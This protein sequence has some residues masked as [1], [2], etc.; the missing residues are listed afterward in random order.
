MR[1]IADKINEV[2]PKIRKPSSDVSVDKTIIDEKSIYASI[3]DN[4]YPGEKQIDD[5]LD[6]ASELK[7]LDDQEAAALLNIRDEEHYEKLLAA[8]N[9]IKDEIY[10]NRLVLFAPLYAANFCANNC[11]YCAFRTGNKYINRTSLSTEEIAQETKA[12]LEQGHKRIL[13]LTGEHS[14]KS[15]LDSLIK[16]I[17][18]IYSV[19]DSKGN[20]IRRINVEIAPLSDENFR[21]LSKLQ[22]GTYTVFQETYHRETYEKAHIG[23]PKSDFDWRLNVMNRALE[24][25]LNDLGIGVLYG[26][27]DYRFETLAMIRHAKYMDQVYGV[28]PHTISIPRL[29]PAKNAPA[30]YWTR[31]AVSDHDFKKLTAVLRCAVPYT[32]MILS[33]REKPELRSEIFNLGVSQISA[34]SIN[35]P[36]GYKHHTEKSNSKGQFSLNDSRTTGEVINDVIKR[37]FIPSFCTACYRLGRVGEDFMDLAKPGLIKLHCLPNGITTLKE[38]LE[39]YAD[40]DTKRAGEELIKKELQN[41]P[42]DKRRKKV[43]EYLERIEKGERDLYF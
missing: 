36:G 31:H 39:D 41:I 33:T 5:I 27:Y 37:G 43:E 10:G 9:K 38:Y 17:E 28:G 8:A 4:I 14:E 21:E 26:L 30:S 40:D 42:S 34:G 1:Q 25:G 32:G 6:K 29:Q 20:S 24:N 2:N 11:L 15:R 23:G 3:V 19:R 13:L 12:I 7:G 22:I 18:T 16:A 35:E